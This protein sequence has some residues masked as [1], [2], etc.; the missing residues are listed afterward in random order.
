MF[1]TAA[2]CVCYNRARR[3]PLTLS[4]WTA[5]RRFDRNIWLYF[6]TAAVVGFTA[7]GGIYATL[8][9]LYLLRLDLGPEAV[10]L[11]N[12]FGNLGFALACIPAGW[13]VTRF[14]SRRAIM[15]GLACTGTAQA[16]LPQVIF[17]PEA[18][19]LP[20]LL[21]SNMLGA[22]GLALYAVSSGPFVMAAAPAELRSHA[23]SLQVAIW[24]M[25]AF[26][27]SLAGGWLPGVF[28]E[29]LGL[30]LDTAAPYYYPL[31]ISA[32]I[33]AP[34]L[35]A[36]WATTETSRSH[37]GAPLSGVGRFPLAPMVFVGIVLFLQSSGE[38][39]A[40]T[41]FNVYLDDELGAPTSQIGLL[42]AFG[43]LA[44]VPAALITP[45]LTGRLGHPRT[46][47]LASLGVAAGL[48]PMALIPAVGAAGIGFAA[49]VSMVSMARAAMLV[50]QFELV[51]ERWRAAMGTAGTLSVGVSGAALASAGGVIIVRSGFTSLFLLGA[52]LTALGVLVFVALRRS[53][54]RRRFDFR[55]RLR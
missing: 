41:F 39:I 15:V 30:S 24:P 47:A 23:F 1:L 51:P 40:R 38:T 49:V 48:L 13:I 54:E 9:N 43:Q 19:R 52:A 2:R 27:G 29:M 44:A 6:F 16:L 12:A 26:L 28:A 32:A 3:L 14:G 37:E 25:A 34:A 36:M 4:Y 17:L 20:W 7:W 42:F 22:A 21:G 18:A 5:L 31:L 46:F 8:T 35:I 50:Y 53:V 10:G 55:L 45:V 11:V 33:Y